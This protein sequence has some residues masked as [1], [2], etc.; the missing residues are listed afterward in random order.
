MKKNKYIAVKAD[1]KGFSYER[2]C[3]AL[4]KSLKGKFD[5]SLAYENEKTRIYRLEKDI[6]LDSCMNKI[7]DE[8][9]N[10]SPFNDPVYSKEEGKISYDFIEIYVVSDTEI[11]KLHLD[12]TPK[13]EVVDDFSRLIELRKYD[14]H[15]ECYKR[16]DAL[17]TTKG[18]IVQTQYVEVGK[19]LMT[20]WLM[21][22]NHQDEPL[23]M[24][25]FQSIYQDQIQGLTVDEIIDMFDRTDW[26][27]EWGLQPCPSGHPEHIMW[28]MTWMGD[29]ESREEAIR[30]LF[31]KCTPMQLASLYCIY[32]TFLSFNLA[33][34][35]ASFAQFGEK[36]YIEAIDDFYNHLSQIVKIKYDVYDFEDIFGRFRI[37]YLAGS[38]S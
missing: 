37:F 16:G 5:K 11:E 34:I 3:E 20:D 18:N 29:S 19:K 31:K 26:V 9:R 8:V 14:N 36:N 15:Y 35:L 4:E 38:G 22:A 32:K 25:Y 21:K 17:K 13:Y 30:K 10:M 27:N 33:F 28:W 7:L 6:D 24:V 12:E 1:M 23:S 2:A